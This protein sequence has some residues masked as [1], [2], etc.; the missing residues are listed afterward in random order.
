[1][2]IVELFKD[3]LIF[4]TKDWN[5]FFILGI[6]ILVLS[7]V[8][9][10]GAF[11]LALRQYIGADIMAAISFIL[12][13]ILSVIVFGYA[14]S[15]TR[16]TIKNE[17]G[18]IPALDLITNIIDGIK[19]FV[20]RIVYYI[21]PAIVALIIAFATGAFNNLYRVL[22][23]S[24]ASGANPIP[25]DLLLSLVFSI[26]P[27]FFIGGIVLLIFSVLLLAAVAVLA[28]T[29]SLMA[30]INMLDVFKK[31][32]EIGWGS[33]IIWLIIY[34]ILIFA[35]AMI[36]AFFEAIPFVGIIIVLLFFR[37]YMEIFAARTLG[38]IYNESKK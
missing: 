8:S 25:Q 20:L 36:S 16:E 11:G 19:V 14:L 13:F 32:G 28:E 10:L 33:Y 17:D 1:M 21:I 6:V 34:V 5:K 27:V 23:L 22:V 31:I 3:S 4:P 12:L 9:I 29:G 15:I 30:A 26:I 18:D 35:I 38:L 2:D 7:I 24:F 37:P